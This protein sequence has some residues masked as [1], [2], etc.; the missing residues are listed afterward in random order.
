[1]DKKSEVSVMLK[2]AGILFAITLIAGLMLGFVHELTK[3]PIRIQNEKAIQEACLAV[4][5]GKE[6]MSFETIETDIPEELAN[7]FAAN[8]VTVGTI[9]KASDNSG[10]AGFVVE[11]ISSKG[12]GGNIDLFVGVDKDGRV[13]GVSIL[14][15]KETAG[16]GMEA[17]NVLAPQFAGK[18]VS[19]FAYTK[20]GA[21]AENE[22]DAI[23]S[24]TITTKAVTNAVNGGLQ[25]ALYLLE[26]G[27][28]HE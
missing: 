21:S 17:P 6:N 15:I 14:E 1:M 9:Y 8:F 10:F 18:K 5:P 16:L 25:T 24:A 26:G 3:E 11:A 20:T 13:G 27:A 2:E 22:V 28:S 19:A 12:Y 23:S 7:E 4:F